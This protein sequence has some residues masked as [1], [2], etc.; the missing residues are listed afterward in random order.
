[1]A[2]KLP[3]TNFSKG[4]FTPLLYSRVDVPQYQAGV[5]T[6]LNFIIQRYGGMSFRPGFRFAG[7]V[8]N[9]DHNYRMASF[10]SDQD[11][12]Y[13]MLLGDLQHRVMAKGGF[14]VEEDLKIVSITAGAPA[15]LEIPFHDMAVGD[16][17]YFEGNEG[18]PLDGRFAVILSVPD[19]NHVAVNFSTIGLP[20][21]TS[22]T[23]IVRVGA[24][25]PPPAPPAPLPDPEP[26]PDP[27]ETGGGGGSGGGIGAGGGGWRGTEIL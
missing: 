23:G 21:L 9:F 12:G 22:S 11:Q 7:E 26:E 4:E 24:P 27:P 14:V 6:G 25:P 18:M 16:R 15:I 17:L 19:A 3:I 13:I 20:A 10:L 8:D 5:K 1:M 2:A